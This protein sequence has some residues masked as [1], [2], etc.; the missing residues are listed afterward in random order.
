MAES[1][2]RDDP[3]KAAS[4]HIESPEDKLPSKR[5]PFF[6]WNIREFEA[7]LL[8]MSSR[9][10]FLKQ[11]NG[12]RSKF[13]WIRAEPQKCVYRL[14][15]GASKLDD[16]LIEKL[17]DVGW[18]LVYTEKNQTQ[19]KSEAFHVFINSDTNA[20]DLI[21]RENNQKMAA[22]R[23]PLKESILSVLKLTGAIGFI[24]FLIE[25]FNRVYVMDYFVMSS[26]ALGVAQ[27]LSYS[28]LLYHNYKAECYFIRTYQNEKEQQ[29][30][31]IPDWRQVKSKADR[32]LWQEIAVGILG[33]A[34]VFVIAELFHLPII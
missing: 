29:E 23:N 12:S 26:F 27:I 31:E 3:L 14:L 15:L 34:V 20:S 9:G 2:Y 28:V 11:G 5:V 22:S 32:H 17:R 25:F 24:I 21:F 4:I 1:L 19:N 8:E 13:A 10:F 16:S 18:I 7:Y 6:M 30:S 33:I